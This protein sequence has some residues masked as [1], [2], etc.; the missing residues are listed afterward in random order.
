MASFSNKELKWN[1]NESDSSNKEIEAPF[2]RFITIESNSAPITNLS[3]FMIEKVI[4]IS[5]KT[6][7][8]TDEI[9]YKFL[10]QLCPKSLEYLLSA[11]ND[12]WKNSNSQNNG[13]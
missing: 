10:R 8:S 5:L 11:L 13:N 1:L 3:P 2:P 12:I 4:S 7:V 6:A 9:H